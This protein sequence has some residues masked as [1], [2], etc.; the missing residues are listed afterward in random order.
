MHHKKSFFFSL[1]VYLYSSGIAFPETVQQPPWIIL[2]TK[3]TILRFLKA[4][5]L[6]TLNNSI[7]YQK[8]SWGFRQL[9]S[10][11]T[12][13]S[14]HGEIS[15]K[16]DS[17]YEQVQ[18]ILDM[19]KKSPKV[20][21][22]LYPNREELDQAYYRLHQSKNNIRAWY[23]FDHNTIY[24]NADDVHEGILAHEMAHAIIDHFLLVRPPAASA[25]ILARYVDAHLHK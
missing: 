22:H 1:L 21:I 18:K 6:D 8:T 16:L 3:H 17:L 10:V 2:E 12:S 23:V 9:F 15:L 13:E 11:K 5:D 4:E 25:E 14:I 24:I 20:F 19:R 7:D